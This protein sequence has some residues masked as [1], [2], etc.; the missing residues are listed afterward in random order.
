MTMVVATPLEDSAHGGHAAT[1]AIKSTPTGVKQPSTHVPIKE[2]NSLPLPDK[3]VPGTQLTK[4]LPEDEK[5]GDDWI[6]RHEKM[7]RLTGRHPFN[8]EPPPADLMAGYI[9]SPELH[10]VRNHAKVPQ[11]TWEDHSVTVNGL[12]D[13]PKSFSMENLTSMP[14]VDV[15]CT[16]TCAGNRR[17]E[18]NMVK[19]TIGFNWGPAGTACSTWT[20]VRLCDVLKACGIDR[21]GRARYVCLRGPKGELPKGDDGSYGTSISIERAMDPANDVILAYKQNGKLLTPDHGFPIRVIIPG[22][23]GG[24]MIKWLEEI[25]VT[26][27]ES[28]NYYHFF[29]N[30]VLPSVVDED[31]ANSE[32]WWYKPDFI[33]ND[34]N[35]NSAIISP[36]HD[37]ALALAHGAEVPFRGYAYSNGNKIIRCEISIDDGATWKLADITHR[38]AP[39]AAGRHWAWVWWEMKIPM[40]ELLQCREVMCRAWDSCMN[41]QPNTFTWNVMGMMNNCVYRVKIHPTPTPDGRFALAFEHPTIAGPTVGGWMNRAA[42]KEAAAA[43]QTVVDIAP[44][45]PANGSAARVISMAEVEK[46]DTAES[47]WF[48]YEN[49]VYDATPFLKEHPGGADSILLVAG[50]DATDEFNAIHSTRAKKMLIEYYI[51]DL[52]G[53]HGASVPVL[54]GNGVAVANGAAAVPEEL[55]ALNPKKRI[56]FALAEKEE[57]SHNACRFRFALQS[58]QHRFGLPVGKHVFL[59][60]KIDGE[61]VMRAYTP[62]SSDDELGYFDLVIK[63]YRANE[64]PRFP[65]GGKMSQYLD[66][67][68]IGD[69]IEVK[70]PVGHMH[71]LGNG[72]Y[73]LDGTAHS[74]AQIN[75]IAGG[76]GITPMYQ[77]IKAVLK[78]SDDKTQMA[79]L[80]AN[81]S[82]DDIL[83]RKELDALAAADSRFKV[84]YTVD[85]VEEEEDW[86]Y[87]IGFVNRQMVEENLFPAAPDAITVICGPPPMVKFACLPALTAIGFTEEQCIQF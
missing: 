68:A 36:G 39:N 3:K 58:P 11:M 38:A 47:A 87:S 22:Y 13:T 81:Q 28:Q 23:I 20:G 64:H 21:Y 18:Q 66:S 4:I 65:L 77:V 54:N 12:V 51:G 60:A 25:T 44:V 69:T 72:K 82:P 6:A 2:Y 19:K 41:T 80:Y 33:I 8:S 48:V 67:L 30:R 7:I 50:T 43:A 55:V 40:A 32:G 56:N 73:T 14:A 34:L 24:R 75:M 62:A 10:Y 71:Y 35:I 1:E 61:L 49:K 37:Q 78:Q 31:R 16:L 45:T 63:I 70:G 15:T 53:A 86:K 84:W 27:E 26:Y 83:L 46:H 42:D 85:R 79:L 9:T 59:Y 17:K 5:T 76:T 74:T 29:D 52:E 57:L